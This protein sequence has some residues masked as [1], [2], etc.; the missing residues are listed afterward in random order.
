LTDI[1]VVDFLLNCIYVKYSYVFACVLEL[2]IEYVVFLCFD[3]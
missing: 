3:L 2:F 1:K